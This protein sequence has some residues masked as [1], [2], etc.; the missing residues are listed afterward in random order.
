MLR[1]PVGE[2]R[3][4]VRLE[5]TQVLAEKAPEGRRRVSGEEEAA[6]VFA[7][8]RRSTSV[9]TL[10][11]PS[12]ATGMSSSPIAAVPTGSNAV[13]SARRSVPGSRRIESAGR[14]VAA[15]HPG[16]VESSPTRVPAIRLCCGTRSIA[17]PACASSSSTADA[18]GTR[19][20]SRPRRSAWRS[21]REGRHR[22]SSAGTINHRAFREN[23]VGCAYNRT[24]LAMARAYAWERQVVPECGNAGSEAQLK[25][26]SRP[27][28]G[29]GG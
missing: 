11:A 29:C 4:R 25:G 8:R 21:A 28:A 19:T 2:A 17:S 7:A 18:R 27:P 3:P 13:N 9:A 14:P 24:T 16:S 12:F 1:W 5:P 22:V 15:G 6:A 10:R 20:T 23:P 26:T